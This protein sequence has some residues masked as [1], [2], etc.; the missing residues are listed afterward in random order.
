MRNKHSLFYTMKPNW[1]SQ[2]YLLVKILLSLNV[3]NTLSFEIISTQKNHYVQYN[4]SKYKR[5]LA[6]KCPIGI[7]EPTQ[8]DLFNK[9]TH[10]LSSYSR[11]DLGRKLIQKIRGK[12]TSFY[13]NVV[14][15]VIMALCDIDEEKERCVPSNSSKAAKNWDNTCVTAS[16]YVCDEGMCERTSNCYWNTVKE[17]ENRTTRFPPEKFAKAKESLWGYQGDTYLRSVVTFSA[18]GVLIAVLFLV[19]WLIFFIGRYCCC[20]L[21]TSCGICFL[22]SPIPNEHGYQICCQ[23]LLPSMIYF[24]TFVVLVACGIAAYIGNEDISVAASSSFIFVSALV[25]DMGSFLHRSRKPLS[26]IER[27]VDVAAIDAKDVFDDTNYVKTTARRILASFT[28]FGTLYM[29][30]LKSSNAKDS[31]DSALDMFNEQVR[32]NTH[33]KPSPFSFIIFVN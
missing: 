11:G 22:C 20:C 31:F 1:I 17:G 9:N 19:I 14:D 21:W 27:I 12:P 33:P 32:I 2:A 8:N 18:I 16:D 6:L 10:R 25:D 15:N 28:S 7:Y 3:S 23:W 5:N 30:G 26:T 4:T 24:L 29:E 13:E